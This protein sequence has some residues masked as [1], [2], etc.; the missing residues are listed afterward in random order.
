MYTPIETSLMK[1][2]PITAEYSAKALA[3]SI[4]GTTNSYIMHWLLTNQEQNLS[5]LKRDIVSIY[6]NGVNF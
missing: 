2:I 5:D 3:L 6:F 1:F 4:I